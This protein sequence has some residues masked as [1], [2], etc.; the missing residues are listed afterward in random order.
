MVCIYCRNNTQVV[1]SRLR[2]KDNDVWRRRKCTV[3]GALFSSTENIDLFNA[4]KVNKKNNDLEDFSKE[5]ILISIYRS[6]DH[7]PNPQSLA[8]HLTKTALQQILYKDQLS[9]N[10]IIDSTTIERCIFSV[11]QKFDSAGAIKYRSYNSN[12]SAPRD[13]RKSLRQTNKF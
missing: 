11:L 9:T 4:L 13:I 12:L 8:G 6:I 2:K 3:C 1:N 10:P 5:K 7:L